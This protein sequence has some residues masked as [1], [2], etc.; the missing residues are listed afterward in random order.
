MSESAQKLEGGESVPQVKEMI[1]KN[2]MF[3]SR[4][5]GDSLEY[6]EMTGARAPSSKQ[7]HV[8]VK[9]LQPPSATL[10]TILHESGK[11]SKECTSLE[12]WRAGA[13]H[14]IPCIFR[15]MKTL[16]GC[17]ADG[18]IL[19]RSEEKQVVKV[20]MDGWFRESTADHVNVHA[21]M[22]SILIGSPGVGKSTLLCVVAF[23]LVLKY[24]K[25]VLVYRRLKKFDQENCLF[26]LG[27]EDD[28]IVQFTVEMCASQTAVDIYNELIHKKKIANVW[29]LLD[30]FHYPDIPEGLVTFKLLA[31][32]QQV[33]LK[34]Q[35]RVYVYCCLLPCWSKRDL[36]SL[37]N[38]IHKFGADEMAERYYY[39][40]GSVRE[41]TLKTPEEIRKTIDDA[42][43]GMEELSIVSRTFVED[44][45]PVTRE[46][47]TAIR[48]WEQV[49]DSEYAVRALSLRLRSDALYRIYNWA[50]RNEHESLAGSAF[51][52]YFH[53]LAADNM[54][55]LYVSEYDL[56]TFKTPYEPWQ[57]GV[58][59]LRLRDGGAVCWGTKT[60]YE[61]DLMKWRDSEELTYWYPACDN[62]PNIDSIVKIESATGKKSVAY[63]RITVTREHGISEQELKNMNQI[64]YPAD[65]KSKDVDPPI[66]VAV[67]PDRGACSKFV[68]KSSPDV[69]AVRNLF[70]GRVFVG[71][72]EGGSF[73]SCCR[74]SKKQRT[75]ERFASTSPIWHPEAATHGTK[76][77]YGLAVLM[78]SMDMLM[79]HE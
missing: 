43:S 18:K 46:Q 27:Y 67:C 19:W 54:L 1:A 38:L 45:G 72:C 70:P 49:I 35:E 42:V 26:Y 2:K 53:K 31:T 6:F 55:K 39:S 15:Y 76:G 79:V 52:F 20:L 4:T 65:E 10:T 60:N 41:F 22:K 3:S 71:Y 57:Q 77:S 21:M 14:E 40:G 9:V 61:S 7:V 68:L 24:Q 78:L 34:S 8:L 48:Y 5:I 13:V 25:N 47:L 56:L 73:P 37:G 33:D 50:L 59:S 69:E 36:W 32:S 64:F 11:L 28:K 62:F 51:E 58:K 66:F 75:C 23:C 30:G 44:A 74:W 17:T 12:E 63:L 16:G 29:L